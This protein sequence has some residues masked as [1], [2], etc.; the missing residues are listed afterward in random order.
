MVLCVAG[1]VDPEQICAM[2]LEVLPKE[3]GGVSERSYGE[4]EPLEP[5]QQRITQ[6]MEVSMPM[7]SI[8]FKCP[9]IPK[10]PE[11]FRQEVIGDLTAEILCGE[12]SRLYQQL[13]EQGLIDSGFS[14]GYGAIKGL[15]VM[16]MSG[17]SED[18]QAVL[19]A[20]LQEVQR[21]E[22]EG[23]DKALF[24]RLKKSS[25]GRRIRG[26]DSFEGICYRLTMADFD[27]YNYLKF[28]EL[29][30]E[31]TTE[32]VLEMLRTQIRPEQAVLSVI[33]PKTSDKE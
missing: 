29:Y 25:L 17:D 5:V 6:E 16:S 12:S 18:P 23:V 20:I 3:P 13:Y 28:P 1:D 4:Q 19:D 32:D 27:G 7:F 10:G 8:G 14:V 22:Q 21:I 31:I 15:A 11:R 24:E 26:L 9:E 2:A 33:L 30:E